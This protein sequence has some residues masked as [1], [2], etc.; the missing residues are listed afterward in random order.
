MANTYR[1]E[2]VTPERIVL[3]QDV[4]EANAPGSEGDLGV[5][6]YHMP[7]LT[8][9]RPGA[10]RATLADGR[11]SSTI[12]VSGGFLDIAATRTTILADSAVLAEEID[13]GAAEAD[14][15]QARSDLSSAELGS[16]AYHG[17]LK[18]IAFAEARL[19]AAR[20]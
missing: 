15:A 13:A 10:V 2:V 17:A 14:L 12:V 8:A 6:A 3:S 20:G 19:R 16:P 18:A 9:L 5:L 1:L 7:L 4:V 11:S